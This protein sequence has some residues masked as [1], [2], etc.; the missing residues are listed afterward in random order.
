MSNIIFPV[1]VYWEDTDAGGIVYYANYLKFAERAR[2]EALR[3]L[4]IEQRELQEKQGI[5]I[6]VHRCEI[7]YKR[8]AK[9]DDLLT[10]E[11]Q[12]QELGKL[13]MTMRQ[14]IRRADELLA[15]ISVFLACT[16]AEGKPSPWP[17]FLLAPLKT[18]IRE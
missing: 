1:R 18:L 5:A 6:V 8:P 16:N 10:V 4:G 3:R 12:L 11:T 7:D 17:D 15:E 2:T 13:R 9:L 14:H